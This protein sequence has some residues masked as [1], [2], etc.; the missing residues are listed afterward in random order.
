MATSFLRLVERSNRETV[1]IYK[2]LLGRAMKGEVND[3][4]HCFIDD[5]GIEQWVFTG[6]YKASPALAI[7]AAA[8]MTWRLCEQQERS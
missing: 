1:V 7:N 8:R 2:A 3:T 4:A 6:K 5:S